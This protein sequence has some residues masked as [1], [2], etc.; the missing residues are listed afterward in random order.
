MKWPWTHLEGPELTDALVD[1][2]AAQSDDQ[3][4]K[5]TIRE[6]ERLRDNCLVDVMSG[7]RRNNFASGATLR[8]Y[9]QHLAA[10]QNTRP[11]ARLDESRP[12]P[13]YRT[14]VQHDWIDYNGH[15]NESRYLEVFSNAT[16]A[17]MEYVGAGAEYIA[18]GHSYFT[19][20]THI[21]H[22]DEAV[23]GQPLEVTTQVLAADAKRLHLFHTLV[24]PT[25]N[26]VLATGEHMLLHV[27]FKARRTC[28]A[29]PDVLSAATRVA[30]AHA[31]LPRPTGAGRAIGS[32]AA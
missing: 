4:G 2:V 13:L 17:A 27:D 23:E 12:L 3:A 32:P 26:V 14:H 22:L 29:L 16:D 11:A 1:T 19:V 10:L 9:A 31:A 8:A 24:R 5:A 7:L 15:M 21:R 28:P 25:D 18:R 6:L 20:E 30:A